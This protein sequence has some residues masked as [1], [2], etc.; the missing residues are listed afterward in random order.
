MNKKATDTRLKI[1]DEAQALILDRGFGSTTVDS[2]IKQAGVSKGAFFHY[3]ANK[4]ELGHALVARYADIDLA[5]LEN[6][7]EKAEGLSNDPLQQLLIFVKLFEQEVLT[8]EEPYP[9]CLFASY[10]HQSGL[11][12]DEIL[13]IIRQWMLTWRKRVLEKMEEIVRQYPIARE[14]DIES[15]ADMLLVIFE[16][17]FV[18][19]QSLRDTKIIARQL[20]HYHNYLKFLFGVNE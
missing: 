11:F 4:E 5:H 1:M 12:N 19:S 13:E 9:G 18:L 10:L 8:L 15:L 14:I 6:T 16:G 3:F 17:A 7:L 20:S 2:I